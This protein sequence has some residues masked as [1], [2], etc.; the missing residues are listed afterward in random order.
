MTAHISLSVPYIFI[1]IASS[2]GTA[3]ILIP[4]AS[5]MPFPVATPIL[6]PVKEPGPVDTA[7][8]SNSSGLTSVISHI[9]SIIGRSV[10]E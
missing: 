5:A 1:A 2:V 9:S 3:A 10:C 7:T 6:N 4:V 8:T